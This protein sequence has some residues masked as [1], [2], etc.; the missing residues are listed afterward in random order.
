MGAFK[1][2]SQI[3]KTQK[4]EVKFMAKCIQCELLAKEIEQFQRKPYIVLK[5]EGKLY[6]AYE[7]EEITSDKSQSLVDPNAK[8]REVRDFPPS[9]YGDWMAGSGG[10][11]RRADQRVEV[12]ISKPVTETG[13]D[14][15]F[16]GH[17]SDFW[18]PPGFDLELVDA[19]VEINSSRITLFG[20][21][22]QL[23]KQRVVRAYYRLAE[24][25]FIVPV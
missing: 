17:D 11:W 25:H 20:R 24:D 21:E 4:P 16:G 10:M 18:V 14:L 2:V 6:K 15:A 8:S 19:R 7:L 9:F 1:G 12:K 5:H 13:E 22:T 3:K 23:P